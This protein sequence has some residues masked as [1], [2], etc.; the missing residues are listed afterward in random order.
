MRVRVPNWQEKHERS[1]EES[2]KALSGLEIVLKKDVAAALG[3]SRSIL[4]GLVRSGMPTT[5]IADAK[6]KETYSL[7]PPDMCYMEYG[8]SRVQAS[9][10]RRPFSA[11]LS[12]HKRRKNNKAHLHTQ[13]IVF[14]L[15]FTGHPKIT[16]ECHSSTERKKKGYTYNIISFGTN[17]RV[18][19]RAHSCCTCHAR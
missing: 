16:V 17:S 1:L 8:S 19:S 4:S 5:S 14:N 9:S 13:T 2:W 7:L 10:A 15:T 3:V 12:A 6:A 18:P 11:R